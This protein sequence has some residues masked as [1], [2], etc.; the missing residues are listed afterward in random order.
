MSGPELQ[1][2]AA[3]VEVRPQGDDVVDANGGTRGRGAS[4]PLRA[5]GCLQQSQ[6]GTGAKRH[7]ANVAKAYSRRAPVIA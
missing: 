3:A 7:L 4:T 6:P 2:G 5:A 1:A